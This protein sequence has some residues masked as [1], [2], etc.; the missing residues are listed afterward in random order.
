MKPIETE[1]L[2]L[3][4]FRTGDEKDLYEYLKAPEMHCFVDMKIETLEQAEL[5]VQ[6]RAKDE[7]YFAIELKESGKVIGEIF[8]HPEGTG[9]TASDL[10]TFSPC[11]MLNA[12]Y[13]GKGYGYEAAYAYLNSLFENEGIRRV[14][15]YTED[16][17]LACQK[18]CKKLGARKE[19]LFKEFVSFVNDENGNPIYENTLQYAILKKEW[20]ANSLDTKENLASFLENIESLH[21]TELGLQR[22]KKNIGRPAAETEEELMAFCKNLIKAD[23]CKI[24]K[25]GKNWYCKKDDI[26]ITVNSYN[27][28]I[29]TGK[30]IKKT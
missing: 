12:D 18:L 27:Y 24:E 13:K 17:N 15:I 2:L 21:T 7:F 22:I 3:R 30:K 25:M 26:E 29:I 19:G 6:G 23:D 9:P 16:Y 28:C 8:G 20:Y 14:Y 1:H 11:W 5:E 4:P 10:D